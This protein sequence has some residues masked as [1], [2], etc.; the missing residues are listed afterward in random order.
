MDTLRFFGYT[1]CS[2]DEQA[3]SGNGLEAQKQ[4]IINEIASRPNAKLVWIGQDAGFS[5]SKADNRPSLQDILKRLR[6]KE[7]DGLIVAKLDRLS[8]SVSDFATITELA[9]KQHWSL[10]VLDAK[11]DTTSPV[12]EMMVNI[13]ATFAQFER[14]LISQR[15]KDGLARVR[16]RGVKLGSSPIVSPESIAEL[17]SLHHSGLSYRQIAKSLNDR[18]IPSPRGSIWYPSTAQKILLRLSSSS[19][20]RSRAQ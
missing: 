14:R 3:E 7:A 1:R 9:R 2:T 6:A 12:G 19:F 20:H 4:A 11:V 15:T 5:G 18:S 10:L 8:R 17:T 16:A 13:L